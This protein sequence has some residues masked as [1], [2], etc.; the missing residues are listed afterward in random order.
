[1]E[2][3][4]K[5]ELDYKKRKLKRNCSSVTY[6]FFNSKEMLSS[7]NII[8]S[9][10]IIYKRLTKKD[11]HSDNIIGSNKWIEKNLDLY[12]KS[13]LVC[14][15][16]IDDK[17][18]A[19]YLGL[20]KN[21]TFYYTGSG[22]IDSSYTKFSISKILFLELIKYLYTIGIKKINCGGG[23][24][25]FKEKFGAYQIDY[26][27]G[28]IKI[29]SYASL[30]K[31]ISAKIPY[32]IINKLYGTNITSTIFETTK[33]I[34]EEDKLFSLSPSIPGWTGY[35]YPIP[36]A[37]FELCSCL[38]IPTH[39][40]SFFNC[41]SGFG[42]T[43]FNLSN[44]PFKNRGG[45]FVE[46]RVYDAFTRT[47]QKIN[48][49]NFRAILSENIDFSPNL[50]SDFNV[51]F[52]YN[53]CNINILRLLI[54]K[55]IN[56]LQITRRNVYFIYL[57]CKFNIVLEE[58]GFKKIHEKFPVTFGWRFTVPASIY[59]FEPEHSNLS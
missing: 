56:S 48:F 29:D 20:I 36:D 47:C 50:I 18:A 38:D 31:L 58:Y 49:S 25:G 24:F 6:S 23:D 43:D 21:N 59:L 8:E 26:Y 10:S 46:R 55:I 22:F 5:K 57:N 4:Q 44:Y 35:A 34:P 2:K 41:N 3:S 39:S 45:L 52:A 17:I 40:I 28:E 32:E 9:S 16:C 51:F 13:G 12:K 11:V 37:V 1:M 15:M 33:F 54:E 14:F 27:S 30:D 19:T 42:H 53:P 7:E